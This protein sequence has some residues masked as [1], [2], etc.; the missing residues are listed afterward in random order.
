MQQTFIESSFQKADEQYESPLR[1]SQLKEFIGQAAVKERLEVMVSAA[2]QRNE[3]LSHCLFIGPPG[4]GK[5]T[6]AHI[7][8]KAMGTNLVA[9]SGPILEKPGDLAGLLTSLKTGDIFFIDEI[10]RLNKQ[11]EEYLYSAMEDFSLDI[12]IDSGPGARSIQVKLNP[13]TLAAATTRSGLLSAPLRSRFPFTCRLDYYTEDLLKTILMRTSRI[14]NVPVESSA[15]EQ[16]AARSRGTPRIANNLLRWVRDYAQV[17]TNNQITHEGTCAALKL[18]DI[19]ERGLDEMD[20]KILRVIIDYHN[21]GPVGVGTIA[22]AVGEC[23]DTLEEVHEPYLIMQGFLE[24]T[25]RGRKA[26]AL[27]YAHLNKPFKDS[28]RSVS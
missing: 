8:S 2:L 21:G 10:H 6:L 4:L 11:V 7:L 25:P 26:T 19:D 9:T 13:F 15:A 16:V 24:R 20:K 14:L 28:A 5:T 1:P 12:L 17:K 3:P 23:Q 22:A 18:L 27:A